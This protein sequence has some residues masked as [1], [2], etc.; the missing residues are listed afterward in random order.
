MKRLNLLLMLMLIA[1]DVFG[2]PQL[3]VCGCQP[4]EIYFV[5]PHPDF[6][7]CWT[8]FYY[9]SNYGQDIEL[10]GRTFLE[11]FGVLLPDA[12]EESLYRIANNFYNGTQ[13]VS[14]NGGFDWEITNVVY[15]ISS[16][17]F[18]SASGVISGEVYRPMQ[19][20]QNYQLERS[21]Y[22]GS[23]YISCST[24]GFPTD[25]YIREVALGSTP[26]E[27]YLWSPYGSM[28]Y[29]S[30]YGE[31]FT[32]QANLLLQ[33]G[34]VVT[35]QFTNGSVPGEIFGIEE[36]Y[37]W[38][39]RITDYGNNAEVISIFPHPYTWAHGL[40]SGGNPG[41]LYFLLEDISGYAGCT[42][43]IHHTTN[44]GQDWT[45][46]SHYIAWSGIAKETSPIPSSIKLQI[47]PNPA[48]PTTWISFTLSAP[49]EAT[50]AVYNMLGVKVTTLA[51]G[52]Q[53]PGVH[54]Y[55]WD[56]SSQASGVYVVR[57]ETVGQITAQ[58]IVVLR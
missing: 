47:Y 45:M 1:S 10:R 19:H 38:I 46:N 11:N 55:Y 20:P 7:V 27:V 25:A 36:D 31:N 41:E 21:T 22:F 58:R 35:T 44:Y 6:P 42:I 43:E 33:T 8:G 40:A 23:D 13:Q 24:N 49:Q 37:H 3:I 17:I 4:G 48:N 2:S 5:G 12:E 14:F 26:G 53:E 52:L 34:M 30:D 56:A 54:T 50:L 16:N 9:S 57:L 29:S 28:Y 51:G 39:W 32:Y 18:S 15:G